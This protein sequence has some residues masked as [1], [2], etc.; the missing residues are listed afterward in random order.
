MSDTSTN[1]VQGK[2]VKEYID[3]KVRE[4]E[5]IYKDLSYIDSFGNKLETMNTANCYVISEPGFY[6]LPLVYGNGIK[7]GAPNSDSYTALSGNYMIDFSNYLGNKIVSPYIT[8]DTGKTPVS[9]TM[10]WEDASGM[11]GNMDIS[12]GYLRFSVYKIPG[13]GG[14]ALIGIKDSDG[15]VMWS[16]HI[17]LYPDSLTPISIW[18]SIPESGPT[19]G[20]E[21]KAM[22]VNLGT[23]WL[24]YTKFKSVNPHYQWGRKDPIPRPANN[25]N[26][27]ATLYNQQEGAFG[28]FG[29]DSDK[30]P[31]KT[32]M[33]SIRMPNKFF[34]EYDTSNYNWMA[35][36]TST[37]G[38]ENVGSAYNLWD[39]KGTVGTGDVVTIKTIYDPCPYGWKV[40]NG[41]VFKGFTTTR[42]NTSTASQFNVIGGFTNGWTFKRMYDD[43]IGLF[44]PASGLR[45]RG[46]GGLFYVSSIGYYWSSAS[47]SQAS[48][49]FLYFDAGN[50]LPVN[51]SYRAFGFS[52]RPFTE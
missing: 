15:I 29:S 6:K 37:G 12:N 48:A 38:Q 14:N 43:P 39:A 52:V 16:W 8:T 21:Y 42:G 4:T 46:S 49:Y 18:N 10:L 20:T 2:V 36:F 41:A 24:D 40:P 45:Y 13:Y 17:W 33:N 11:I 28:N 26:T 47:S 25:S 35:P 5:N 7:N 32:I 9:P 27:P 30:S 3:R 22:P 23:V 44:F 34:P 1:V 31:D 19:G 50:V 51:Y